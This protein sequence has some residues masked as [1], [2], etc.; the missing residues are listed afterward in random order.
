MDTIEEFKDKK[1]GFRIRVTAVMNFGK[2]IIYSS[3]QGYDK[4]RDAKTAAIRAAV[5][6]L[7]KYAPDLLKK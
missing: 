3:T 2:R 5:A 7:E 4:L 1:G 6:I